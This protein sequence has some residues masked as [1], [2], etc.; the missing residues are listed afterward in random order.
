[1]TEAGDNVLNCEITGIFD[2]LLQFDFDMGKLTNDKLA[3]IYDMLCKN[4]KLRIIYKGSEFVS[5]LKEVCLK[6]DTF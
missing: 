5:A 4:C 2:F 3:R 6:L 1:M